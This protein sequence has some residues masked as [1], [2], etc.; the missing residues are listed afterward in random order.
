MS[1]HTEGVYMVRLF[2]I[3]YVFLLNIFMQT[4]H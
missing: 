1:E 3:I 4:W 2:S